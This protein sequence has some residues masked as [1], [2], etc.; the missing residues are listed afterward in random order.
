LKPVDLI[1]WTLTPSPILE[2][3]GPY[4]LDPNSKPYPWSLS[5]LSPG[6]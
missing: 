1:S 4:L 5:T 6:P 3:C 2:A